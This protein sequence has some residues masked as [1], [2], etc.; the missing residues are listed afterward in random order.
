M[1]PEITEGYP[2]CDYKVAAVEFSGEE[3]KVHESF[4]GLLYDR[5]SVD[6]FCK[7]SGFKDA[8]ALESFLRA[9]DKTLIGKPLPKQALETFRENVQSF[10]AEFG[11]DA[12]KV[13]SEIAQAVHGYRIIQ[14][15]FE[16]DELE[17]IM[18]NGENKPVIVFHRKYGMCKTN[19]SLKNEH[20][21]NVLVAQMGAD[22]RLPYTDLHLV[23]GSRANITLPPLVGGTTITVRKFRFKPM[24]IIDLV[25]SGTL[26][27][28]L[29]AFLWVA[30]EGLSLFPLN[31]IL[32]GG[33]AS[34]KTTVLNALAAFIPPSE[35]VISIEDTLELNPVDRENWVQMEVSRQAS[36]EDL[37]QNSLRMRPDRIL[38]GEVRGNEAEDLFTAMN[39]GTRGLIA[40]LH[41]NSDRDA[42]KRLENSPMNVPRTL[43][44]LIDV[45]AVNHRFF[46]RKT[47]AIVRRITQVSE[48]SRIEDEIALN[49]IYAWNAEEDALKPTKLPSQ[50]KEKIARATG[51]SI[52]EVSEEIEH[53]KQLIEYLLEKNISE[54]DRVCEFVKTYY[55]EVLKSQR[56][57]ATDKD[58]TTED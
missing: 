13:S 30:V 9:Q 35:R 5:I 41:G 24:S 42:I 10:V 55:A 33:T 34:G 17:E 57:T 52:K 20:D 58:D 45:I 40:T 44:P 28:G 22:E 25:K 18:V 54:H 46:D 11:V 12:K 39:V 2:F 47:G 49:E 6:Y 3:Q 51:K 29:A 14:P 1:K 16:D 50:S 38:V 15:L 32:V 31:V 21:M 23:D 19:L 7:S 43:V 53:R 27:S 48:V 37:V 26:S 8:D 56:T 4:I 36:L